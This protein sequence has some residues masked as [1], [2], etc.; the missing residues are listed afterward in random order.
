[1]SDR[2]EI[3]LPNRYGD[4]NVL[5]PCSCMESRYRYVTGTEI[6]YQVTMNEKGD[7]TCFDPSGGPALSIGDMLAPDVYVAFF[8]GGDDGVMY[9]Y[10]EDTPE[11]AKE[12]FETLTQK[13]VT[14]GDGH[15]LSV[16]TSSGSPDENDDCPVEKSSESIVIGMIGKAGSGKDTVADYVVEKYGFTKIAFAD[17]LKQAV[18][19]IFDVDDN[20]MFDREMRE[21]PLPGWEPWSVRK[22]LQFVG[23]ELMRN[24]VDEDIWVKNAASRAKR[25]SKC[26]IS[27]VRFPNEVTDMRKRLEG[28]ANMVFVRVTRPGHEDATGGIK[29]HASEAMIDELDADIDIVND[30]TLEDLYEKVDALIKDVTG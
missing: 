4:K 1:M 7:I 12:A 23:T 22:L 14:A 17:P 28:N 3:A 30:G 8:K 5:V 18:Q 6:P 29:G 24:Q 20:Y 9:V 26:I 15:C 19:V 25:I 21:L 2:K 13:T 27:D 16:E 10:V 11:K